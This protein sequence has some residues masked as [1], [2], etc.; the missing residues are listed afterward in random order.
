MQENNNMFCMAW[1]KILTHEVSSCRK[2]IIC[3]VCPGIGH[4]EHIIIFLHEETS[5]V[6]ILSQDIQNILLLSCMRKLHVLLSYPRTY[7]TY[8]YFPA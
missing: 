4:T 3:S 8:Y 1:D 5:C 2:V 7:R 6:N